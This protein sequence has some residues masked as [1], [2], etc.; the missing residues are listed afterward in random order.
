M[1]WVCSLSCLEL[2]D[3]S[4]PLCSH[5]LPFYQLLPSVSF[6][7][8][9][10][11]PVWDTVHWLQNIHFAISISCLPS[12]SKLGWPP[13]LPANNSV[14][15]WNTSRSLLRALGRFLLFPKEEATWTVLLF[16]ASYLQ[17]RCNTWT[18]GNY[19]VT[20]NKKPR[21]LLRYHPYTHEPTAAATYFQT[22]TRKISS[23]VSH[24]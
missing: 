18:L 9:Y 7:S 15:Y 16:S 21:E 4:S 20:M 23:F 19:F 5:S 13:L 22:S 2:L 3:S 6:P 24:C 17:C 14:D 10:F 8:Q 12:L 11:E 1:C